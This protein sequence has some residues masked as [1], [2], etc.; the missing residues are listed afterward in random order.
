MDIYSSSL[1]LF[2]I[3]LVVSLLPAINP[4]TIFYFSVVF[5]VT[6]ASRLNTV[7]ALKKL[8]FQASD[9]AKRLSVVIL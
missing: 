3:V 5:A 8:F 1:R 7:I 4:S 6:L 2:K 9:I